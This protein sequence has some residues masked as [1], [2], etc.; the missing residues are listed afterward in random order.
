MNWDEDRC[1]RCGAELPEDYENDPEYPWRCYPCTAAYW[2]HI[3]NKAD[4]LRERRWRD[5]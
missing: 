2:R 4:E 1:R 3:D 5:S